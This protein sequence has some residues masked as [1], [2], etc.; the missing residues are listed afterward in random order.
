MKNIKVW[1]ILRFFLIPLWLKIILKL[2]IA[3]I[4]S[5][6]YEQCDLDILNKNNDWAKAFFQHGAENE[7]RTVDL[8]SEVLQWR[9]DF[10]CKGKFTYQ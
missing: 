7:D 5:G 10:G 4:E 3:N 8:I 2:C 1:I 6:K 9:K